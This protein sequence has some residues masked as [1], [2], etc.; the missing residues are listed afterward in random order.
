MAIRVA[1]IGT[2]NVGRLALA[3]L[4]ENPAFDLVGLAV[5]TPDK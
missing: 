1:H 5:S 2:G 4:I 3:E